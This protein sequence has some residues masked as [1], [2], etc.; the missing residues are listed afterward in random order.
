[1]VRPAG[2]EPATYGLEERV[3]P[4]LNPF[5]INGLAVKPINQKTK[6]LLQGIFKTDKGIIYRNILAAPV[7]IQ[8]VSASITFHRSAAPRERRGCRDQCTRYAHRVASEAATAFGERGSRPFGQGSPSS[9]PAC[10]P[11]A[12]VVPA[13]CMPRNRPALA[14]QSCIACAANSGPLSE[15]RYSGVPW[16]NGYNERFN[17][18]LR[19]EVLNAEW[20]TTTTQAQIV[21]N[22]WLRQYNHVRP[23][24]ALN[25]RPPVP[26][27]LIRNGTEPGG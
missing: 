7:P 2:F 20:F 11:A 13:R 8:W 22:Q 15:R 24:Q 17:G 18:T 12:V 25:M 19:R 6:I 26:E 4:V 5:K 10:Y 9:R 27:T 16:E 23:H 14:S 21:I 1:M 3:S